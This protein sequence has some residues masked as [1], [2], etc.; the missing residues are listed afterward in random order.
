VAYG[1]AADD[2]GQSVE[3]TNAGLTTYTVGNLT[4]GQWFFAVYA[5]NSAGLASDLSN[6]ATKTIP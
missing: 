5:V 6:V 2:L 1:R 3:I 4:S